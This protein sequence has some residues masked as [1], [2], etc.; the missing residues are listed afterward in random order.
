MIVSVLRRLRNKN[1]NVEWP[2][3]FA[4]KL[5]GSELTTETSKCPHAYDKHVPLNQSTSGLV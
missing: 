2:S 5:Q 3:L 4:D 1:N